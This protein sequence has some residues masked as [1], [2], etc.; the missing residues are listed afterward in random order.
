MKNIKINREKLFKLYM[1]EVNR[2]ADIFED[3]STFTPE[4]L[5]VIV[6]QV[7]EDNPNLITEKGYNI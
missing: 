1:K 4:E 6:A 2:I 7:L 5:I 3:K